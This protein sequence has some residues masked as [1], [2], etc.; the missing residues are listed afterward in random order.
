[1]ISLV[2]N[3]SPFV[4]ACP[5]QTR[6]PNPSLKD[7]DSEPNILLNLIHDKQSELGDTVQKLT[8]SLTQTTQTIDQS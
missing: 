4:N 2:F 6:H 1:M 5:S 8:L 7:W 3:W